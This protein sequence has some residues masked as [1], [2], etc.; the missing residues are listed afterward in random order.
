MISKE[1]KSLTGIRGLAALYVII[2]HWDAEISKNL[3]LSNS[4]TIDTSLKTFLE[5]GYLSVDLFFILSG[6]VLSMSSYK[7]FHDRISLNDYRSFMYKR[8]S[9]IFPLYLSITLVYFLMF[10][11]QSRINLAINFTL[12]QGIIHN[13]NNSIIPPGWSLTNEWIIYFIFPFFLFYSLKIQKIWILILISLSIL[14]LISS[15]RNQHLN[16]GNYSSLTDMHGFNPTI[17]FT[18]GPASFLR[19]ISAYFLGI[20]AFLYYKKSKDNSHLKYVIIPSFLLLFFNKTDILIILSM[21]FL[22]I[23][24][25]KTN[26]INRFLS[27]NVIYFLGLISYSLY[28]NHYIFIKTYSNVSNLIGVDSNALSF[29]YVLIGTLMFSSMTY[30]LIEKPG[31]LLFKTI[32]LKI[33]NLQVAGRNS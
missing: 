12:L 15:I 20:F 3:Q 9:R 2:Y 27:S 6:F 7:I 5:H 16:W 1:I 25:T 8:F 33:N 32:R 29:W 30:Y 14:L 23:Y 18:R 10:H 26:L 11:Q 22:I 28:V 19:T 31:M 17:S 24:L 21:P 13:F 4:I